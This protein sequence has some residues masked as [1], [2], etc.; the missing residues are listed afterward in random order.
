MA[1]SQSLHNC[2]KII[3]LQREVVGV[4]ITGILESPEVSGMHR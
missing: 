2:L 4:L 3:P 1:I